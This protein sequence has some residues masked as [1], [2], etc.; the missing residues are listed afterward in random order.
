MIRKC[1]KCGEEFKT[2]PSQVK[3]GKGKYCSH[4]CGL[5]YGKEHRLYKNK[6]RKQ[7]QKE[8]KEKH[9]DRVKAHETIS[10][11]LKRNKIK[12]MPCTVCG[13]KKSEA[14]HE[15]YSKPLDVTWLCRKHHREYDKKLGLRA[16]DFK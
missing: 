6:T 7:T 1:L 13:D 5:K 11:A 4:K 8:Y 15:D 12:K 14:H 9:P 10:T 16:G 2:F 3:Q